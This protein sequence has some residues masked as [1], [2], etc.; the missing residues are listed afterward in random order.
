MSWCSWNFSTTVSETEHCNTIK[1]GLVCQH[2]HKI[3]KK[4]KRRLSLTLK[5]EQW[6]E[7]WLQR[8]DKKLDRGE[9]RFTSRA[10]NWNWV[11]NLKKPN[12]FSSIG[13][14]NW[15][16]CLWIRC[17]F[18]TEWL[19]GNG[20]LHVLA[21]RWMSCGVE[22]VACCKHQQVTISTWSWSLFTAKRRINFY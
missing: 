4:S 10:R 5:S 16:L 20:C 1:L 19:D 3:L 14:Y 12:S 6:R 22:R 9:K 2:W 17:W 13:K 18:V 15:R 21:F 8:R 7:N 11:G